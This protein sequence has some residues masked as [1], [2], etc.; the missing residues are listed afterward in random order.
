MEQVFATDVGKRVL[1]YLMDRN[2]IFRSTHQP[3]DPHGTAFCE[4]QRDV[5]LDVL[6]ILKKK[7]DPD[8]FLDEAH[9][10]DIDN[11]KRVHDYDP[12]KS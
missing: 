5:V 8:E 9:Q 7:I 11:M 10:S 4:G 2:G 6:N 12:L 1:R 3:G